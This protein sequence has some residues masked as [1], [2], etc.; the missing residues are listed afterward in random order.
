MRLKLVVLVLALFAVFSCKKEVNEN[1]VFSGKI[2]NQIT[3]SISISSLKNREVLQVIKLSDSGTFAD[4]FKIDEGLYTLLHG[5]ESTTIYLK[6]GFNINLTLDTKEFD[7][8]IKYEGEGAEENNLLAK[9]F[10]FED[11]L[12]QKKSYMY[13][14][15]LNENDF[16]KYADSIY[17]AEMDITNELEIQNKD[18]LYF[19]QNFIEIEKFIKISQYEMI[20]QYVTNDTAFKVSSN[21]PNIENKVDL[22]DEKMLMHP[23]YTSFVLN[24]YKD[25]IEYEN[26]ETYY[27]DLLNVIA[28]EASNDSVKQELVTFVARNNIQYSK[29]LDKFYD[30]FISLVTYEKYKEEITKKYKK[31]LK[32]APGKKSPDFTCENLDGEM[33]SLADLAGK[34]VYIDVWAVWCSPCIKEVPFLEEL[35]A[36]FVGEDIVFVSIDVADDVSQWKAFVEK[37]EMTSLQL[38]LESWDVDFMNKYLITGIPRFIIL[39][40]EGYII[41]NNSIRPSNP[42]LEGKLRDLLK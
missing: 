21:Y 24:I 35:K 36:K 38:R 23:T 25:K 42:K 15:S 32:I 27:L 13:Y 16:L 20:H 10:L 3:D 9:K 12:G 8:T 7:E 40:K 29:D 31:L 19:I 34:I 17:N 6:N 39:D 30:T 4:T 2:D 37:N 1:I 11:N 41:D 28:D 14:G 5:R 18:F 22:N 33:I 26:N